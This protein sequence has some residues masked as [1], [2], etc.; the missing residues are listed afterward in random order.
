MTP[1]DFEEVGLIAWRKIGNKQGKLYRM[2]IDVDCSTKT[3]QLPCNCEAIEAITYH[4]EDWDYASTEDANG[5][6]RS[7]FVENWIEGQKRYE[8]PLYLDGKYVKYE[9]VGDQ[10]YI[11]GDC[12]PIQILYKGYEADEDGLPLITEKE[13]DAIACFCA[14]IQKFK[15]GL[16]TSNQAMLQMAQILEQ[17]WMKMCDQARVADSISQNDMNRILDART[18]WNRK[19]FNKSYKPVK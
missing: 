2:C 11:E 7:S 8:D 3:V 10:I 6:L 15:T 4:F 12:G 16:A 18:S 5:D 17:Q 13:K 14:Y 1:E 19:V 9:K